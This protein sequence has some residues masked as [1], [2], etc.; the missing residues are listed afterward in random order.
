MDLHGDDDRLGIQ[1]VVGNVVGYFPIGKLT[2]LLYRYDRPTQGTGQLF[3][4]TPQ[5]CFNGS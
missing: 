4:C 1:Y 5:N 2:R 3:K